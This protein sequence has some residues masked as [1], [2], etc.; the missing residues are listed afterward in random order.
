MFA[1]RRLF[2]FSL[3]TLLA[4]TTACAIGF[5]WIAD[6]VTECRRESESRR[7]FE[8][9]GGRCSDV[10]A[11]SPYWMTNV[12]GEEAWQEVV[13]VRIAAEVVC[14]VDTSFVMPS[15]FGDD[16]MPTL[17]R[18]HGLQTVDIWQVPITNNAMQV[19]ARLPALKSVTLDTVAVSDDGLVLLGESRSI[20]SL[21]LHSIEIG[22]RGVAAL[23]KC[24][25]TQPNN[26]Y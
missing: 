23:A 7:E 15:K 8:L 12:V 16:A 19:L 11:R 24:K 5:G 18:F 1:R 25:T 6:C 9:A 26:G 13:G 10:R 21:R 20:Q 3:A 14:G 4:F 2:R 17:E 22:E